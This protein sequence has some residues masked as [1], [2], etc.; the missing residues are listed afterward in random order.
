MT[1][2]LKLHALY[3][4]IWGPYLKLNILKYGIKNDE[5]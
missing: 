1:A 3:N 5:I 2:C 4:V